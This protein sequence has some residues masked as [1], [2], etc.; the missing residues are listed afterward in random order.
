L[1]LTEPDTIEEGGELTLEEMADLGLAGDQY[2][3]NPGED[4]EYEEYDEDEEAL[5]MPPPVVPTEGLTEMEQEAVAHNLT[6]HTDHRD[7]ELMETLPN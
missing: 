5:P 6:I 7:R 2:L 1:D 4:Q 3:N